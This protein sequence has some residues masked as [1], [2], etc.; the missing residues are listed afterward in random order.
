MSLPVTK[1]ALD[2]LGHRLSAGDQV[3]EVDLVMIA[4]VAGAYQ[5]ALDEA[6]ARLGGLGYPPTTRVKTTGTLVEKLRREAPMRLSQMQDL[7]GARIS[8]EPW[9]RTWSVTNR[10]DPSSR[11]GS[12]PWPWQQ[13]ST[14]LPRLE[15]PRQR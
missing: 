10:E 5:Q 3:I 11:V 8:E 6:K 14:C 15:D 4:Q 12:W 7:A 2:R 9:M 1:T 13:S